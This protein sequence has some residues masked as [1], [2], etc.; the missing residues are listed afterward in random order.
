VRKQHFKLGRPDLSAELEERYRQEKDARN[1]VRLLAMRMGA[2]GA[3]AS[4]DI[5]DICG[6]S[7]A[8]FFEWAKSFREGGFDALLE[9]EKP[10]PK[11][12][13]LRGVPEAVV[14]ELRAGVESGRWPT[15]EAARI[16]LQ[17]E[18]GIKRPYVTVWSWLKKL[19]GVLRV[20]R[21]RHPENDP[22]AA[23]KFKQELG[24]KLEA[25]PVPQGSR[26]RVWVMDEARFG[27][28][29]EMRRVWISKGVRPEVRR[30]TRYEW[31]Y[32]YGALEVVEGRAEFLHLPT[33]NLD[34]N[35][36]F[37]EHLR[38]SDPQA[39]HVVIAD[40]AGFHLREGDPRLPEGVHIV[41]L[42][43]YSPELNPCEQL[44]D[45]LKD[46]EGFSNGLFESISS[47]RKALR[48]GL[49]RFWD[50]AQAVLSLIGRPWLQS[51]ANATAKS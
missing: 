45:V 21:P 8:T 20:P 23:D 22:A 37:L 36:I 34:C 16:W 13:K 50:D 4:Q 30:Q 17:K 29:T 49:E 10:G 26:V 33:V 47:L 18:R 51:Q 46:T 5:A 6:V 28:H 1:K 2:S 14:K 42:P 9:R 44:W 35:Q 39:H 3:H 15:A 38:S 24:A 48:P 31:D 32:L 19:G 12:M 41:P 25:L 27:L 11:G 43:P 40:Q 7:R